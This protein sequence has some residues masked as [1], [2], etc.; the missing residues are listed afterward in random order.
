VLAG[1]LQVSFHGENGRKMREMLSV[2]CSAGLSV[3]FGAPIGGVLFSYEA[4]NYLRIFNPTDRLWTGYRHL[5][6]TQ[7]PVAR[8]SVLADCCGRTQSCESHGHRKT[9]IIRSEFKRICLVH[10]SIN[11]LFFPQINYKCLLMHSNLRD[12]LWR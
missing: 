12:K 4:S 3:A 6:P 8:V 7:S 11:S 1:K 9:S 2:A 10:F 5:L